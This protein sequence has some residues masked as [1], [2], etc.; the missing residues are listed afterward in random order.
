MKLRIARKICKAVADGS[1]RYHPAQLHRALQR[2]ERT[3]SR[4]GSGRILRR[5]NQPFDRQAFTNLPSS[6][7]GRARDSASTSRERRNISAAFPN[8]G[9]ERRDLS[10]GFPNPSHGRRDVSA[11]TGQACR[12]S[13][14]GRSQSPFLWSLVIR[15]WSFANDE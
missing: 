5:G 13:W 2:T 3:K 6:Q 12:L 4:E 11:G 7:E 10:A 9:R 1:E 14:L 15:P 8:P